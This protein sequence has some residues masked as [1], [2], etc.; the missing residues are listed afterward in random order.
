MDVLTRSEKE[1]LC[2]VL[3]DNYFLF[4]GLSSLFNHIE[5]HHIPYDGAFCNVTTDILS[6]KN[7]TILIDCNI[8]ISGKWH[9]YKALNQCYPQAKRV[10]LTRWSHWAMW[11]SECIRDQQLLVTMSTRLL[12]KKLSPMLNGRSVNKSEGD[13]LDFPE[14]NIKEKKF[15]ASFLKGKE[16]NFLARTSMRSEKTIYTLRCAIQSKFGFRTAA[17]MVSI[18][19]RNNEVFNETWIHQLQK[20]TPV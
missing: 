6:A 5:L 15:L 13:T 3:T 20:G 8:F 18:F 2:L 16:V 19:K 11:P 12:F 9:G 10:W 4:Y 1:T 7:I 14:F 17:W